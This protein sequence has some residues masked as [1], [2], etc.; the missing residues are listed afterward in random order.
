MSIF[1]LTFSLN[2]GLRFDMSAHFLALL[3]NWMSVSLQDRSSRVSESPFPSTMTPG[4][5]TVG[6]GESWHATY[7]AH[8]NQ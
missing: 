3:K 6:S 2:C 1:P 5:S 7:S 8:A 4:W